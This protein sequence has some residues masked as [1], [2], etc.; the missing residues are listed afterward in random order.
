VYERSQFHTEGKSCSDVSR[1][2]VLTDPSTRQ[3]AETGMA[4]MNARLV[5][6]HHQLQELNENL[7][8][9]RQRHAGFL[10]EREKKASQRL[11]ISVTGAV[12]CAG[13]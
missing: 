3:E 8:A 4:D 1:V 12:S 9:S 2:L 7:V 13:N 10:R 6:A 5:E 11:A